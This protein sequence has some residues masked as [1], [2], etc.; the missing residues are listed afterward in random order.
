MSLSVLDCKDK[1]VESWY[2]S[3]DVHRIRTVGSTQGFFGSD[4][5]HERE[6]VGPEVHCSL[7]TKVMLDLELV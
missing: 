3:P 7:L 2:L 5:C 6:P 4:G 1:S